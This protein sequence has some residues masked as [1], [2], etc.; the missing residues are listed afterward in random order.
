MRSEGK[1][2][3]QKGGPNVKI[4]AKIQSPYFNGKILH[5]FGSIEIPYLLLM[6]GTSF[7]N[8]YLS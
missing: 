3:K 7:L 4:I 2:K 6:F 5:C 1:N 8:I